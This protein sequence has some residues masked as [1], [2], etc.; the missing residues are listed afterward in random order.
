MR[1]SGQENGSLQGDAPW[2]ARTCWGRV[3]SD[4]AINRANNKQRSFALVAMA[5]GIRGEKKR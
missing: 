1:A 2:S 4:N 3:M 5:N